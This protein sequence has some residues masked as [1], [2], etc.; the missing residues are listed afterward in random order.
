MPRRRRRGAT[1][2]HTVPTGLAAHGSAVPLLPGTDLA[3]TD[4]VLQRDLTVPSNALISHLSA[5]VVS[6]GGDVVNLVTGTAVAGCLSSWFTVNP[7][8][9]TAHGGDWSDSSAGAITLPTTLMPATPT[10]AVASF[11]WAESGTPQDACLNVSPE[12]LLTVS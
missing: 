2:S 12:V 10:V 1:Y 4:Q 8:M 9:L 5:T 6:Q 7:P 11:F 3:A